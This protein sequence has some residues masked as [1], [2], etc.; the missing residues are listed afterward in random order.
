MDFTQE[1]IATL[2]DFDGATPPAPTDRSAVILPMTEREYAGL[3]AERVLS[4]LEIVDPGEVIV[5][6]SAPDPVAGGFASWLESF[7]LS[8]TVVYCD[9]P[10]LQGL[11]ET[12]GLEG[13]TGKGR[14]VWVGLG[15]ATAQYVV[16]QDSDTKR[17]DEHQVAKLLAPVCAGFE[18]SKAY[19]ARVEDNS[20]YGRLLRLFVEPLVTALRDSSSDPLLPYLDAFRYALAG[21]AAMS[22]TLAR[23]IQLDRRWGLEIGMLAELF[24][25]AGFEGTAQVD[26]G[27]H[28]HDHRAVS[29]DTG[30]SE[31]STG[32]GAALFRALETR[33]IDVDYQ[34]LSVEYRQVA[35]SYVERYEADATFNELSY[36]AAAELTQVETYADAIEAPPAANPL[37]AW[38]D[39]SIS[40]AELRE[41]VRGDLAALR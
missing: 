16:F 2:H 9:G 7:D 14:D 33:G 22:R 17:Y 1:R 28:E 37:P 21:E 5:P 6:I 40:T 39:S 20:L 19:Y 13:A 12:H 36:D 27:R 18:F 26:L 32:V 38:D 34:R 23:S 25:T 15:L 24:E 10:R 8:L 30:L 35:R 41:A 4:T 29:G 31:M 11:L 3:A